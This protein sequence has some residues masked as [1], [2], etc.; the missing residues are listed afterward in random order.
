MAPCASPTNLSATKCSTWSATWRCWGS[1]CWVRW[2]P[3]A[4]DT[5]CIPPWSRASCA[6]RRCGKKSIPRKRKTPRL[7][8]ARKRAL[9]RRCNCA[10]KIP[11]QKNDP[12]FGRTRFGRTW[13]GRTRCL[14][15]R[16]FARRLGRVVYLL[17]LFPQQSFQLGSSL[18][19]HGC[20]KF[21]SGFLPLTRELFHSHI[22]ERNVV[23]EPLQRSLHLR[24]AKVIGSH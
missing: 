21:P 24:D 8:T 7:P 15:V 5:L 18:I 20:G 10:S 4:P 22:Q 6:T 3:T 9:V 16:R 23:F 11:A 17:G 12:L 19:D 13:F 1:K 2:W 14:S